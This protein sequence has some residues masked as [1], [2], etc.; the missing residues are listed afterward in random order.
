MAEIQARFGGIERVY[1]ART[2]YRITEALI[3]LLNAKLKPER[4]Q[5]TFNFSISIYFAFKCR[6][7]QATNIAISKLAP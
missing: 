4:I 2:S 3:I 5:K 6:S 7:K 1:T